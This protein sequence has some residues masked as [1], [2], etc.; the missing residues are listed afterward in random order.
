MDMTTLPYVLGVD[1]GLTGAFVLCHRTTRDL[2][3]LRMP[4]KKI[5]ASGK[6]RTILD[7]Q[8]AA[9]WLDYHAN[10]IHSGYVEAVS[11]RPRQ[12][13]AFN[14]G[15]STGIIHGLLYG[16]IIPFCLIAP[17]VWKAQFG[18]K[19]LATETKSQKKSEAREIAQSLF[20]DHAH[21]FSRV[22][23]DGVAEAA[24]IALYGTH[25]EN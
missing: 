12:Q 3:I 13:G 25:L 22:M 17:Q 8:Q 6:T 23:D 24:L 16:N 1:P 5:K 7:G 10:L 11:S 21:E 9:A 15:L 4:T 2:R 20:P 14:F 18:I 19:R